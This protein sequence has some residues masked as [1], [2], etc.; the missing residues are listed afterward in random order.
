MVNNIICGEVNHLSEFA[1]MMPTSDP[2]AYIVSNTND[3]GEGSFRKAIDD[4]NSNASADKIIFNI[5]KTDPN[6]DAAKGIWT[7]KPGTYYQSLLDSGTVIDGT[8][9]RIIYW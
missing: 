3:S 4:A 1:I 8:S 2:Q 9:Q 5:P 6:Y 7:I